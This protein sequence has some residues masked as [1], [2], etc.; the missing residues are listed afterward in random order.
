MKLR[1]LAPFLCAV[2]GLGGC[3]SI[4]E[5]IDIEAT[6]VSSIKIG[7]TR[8]NVE[9]VLGQPDRRTGLVRGNNEASQRVYVYDYYTRGK[10]GNP[11]WL[12]FA[13]IELATGIILVSAFDT[14]YNEN[15]VQVAISYDQDDRVVEIRQVSPKIPTEDLSSILRRAAQ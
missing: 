1:I 3:G 11:L 6:D 5:A 2:L 4:Y 10:E 7:A 8:Q 14:R 12:L 9:K 13:P 15:R